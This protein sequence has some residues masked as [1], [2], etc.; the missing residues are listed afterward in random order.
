MKR[1]ISVL[2]V[3]VM[4][5]ASTVSAYADDYSFSQSKTIHD[6]L[7]LV[8]NVRYV[9]GGGH[10]GTN[11]VIGVNP[12]WRQFNKLYAKAPANSGI[13]IDNYYC[14]FHEDGAEGDTC[15][16]ETFSA[17]AKAIA[18]QRS[19]RL[20]IKPSVL[21]KALENIEFPIGGISTHRFDGLD[22]TGFCKWLVYQQAPSLADEIG[23]TIAITSFVKDLNSFDDLEPAD[24]ISWR[25]HIVMI[26]GKVS[27]GCYIHI[28]STP[29][30]LRLGVTVTSGAVDASEGKQLVRA[31]YDKYNM[32]IQDS[33]NVYTLTT[34][35][36]EIYEDETT[37]ELL[38]SNL[39]AV[40]LRNLNQDLGE[41]SVYTTLG[42]PELIQK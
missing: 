30:V 16:F 10:L 25:G 4:C 38:G 6:A 5:V 29:G 21:Y 3:V 24:F 39:K 2:A 36:S 1:I 41:E 37:G 13:G 9:W 22:C 15:N 7:L 18:Q 40:R 27:P 35:D 31:Y 33:L 11:E 12:I 19:N 34:I 14:P 32:D 8:G 42:L 17:G 26:V 20:N 28:E 23:G